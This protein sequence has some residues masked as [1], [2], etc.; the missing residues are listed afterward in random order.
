MRGISPSID[1]DGS[2]P[3]ADDRGSATEPARQHDS[4]PDDGG[5][6]TVSLPCVHCGEPT[7]CVVGANAEEVFCCNGCRGAYELIQGLGL[8]DFY[9][10]RDQSLGVNAGSSGAARWFGGQDDLFE[11]FDSEAFLGVSKPQ[12][13][14]GGL[15]VSDLSVGGLHC[16]ACA[17]LIENASLQTDGW[18][19]ARVR[20]N[21]HTIRISFDPTVTSLSRIAAIMNRL[22]YPVFP[23]SADRNDSFKQEN[24]RLLIRIAIAGFCAAN[25]MWIAIALYAGEATYVANDHRLLLECFGVGLGVISVLGPGRVFLRGALSSIKTRTPHMD[26]PVALGLAVGTVSGVAAIIAGSGAVYF[27]SLAVLVFLLLVGRWIQFRQQHHAA[28][29]VD[30]LLRMTPRHA[31]LIDGAGR[32]SRVLVDQLAAGQIVRVKAGESIPVDGLIREGETTVDLAL[33]TGESEPKWMSPGDEVSAGT[34]NLSSSIDIEVVRVGG[35][36]RI[37]KVMSSVEDAIS[38]K[39]PI[40]ILADRIGGVFVMIVTVLAI[41]TFIGWFSTGITQAAANATALLIVAC[42]CALALATPLAVAVAIGRSAKRGILIRD[43]SALERLSKPGQIWFDKTGTLTQGR[44]EAMWVTGDRSVL[45][46]AADVEKSCVHPL[47]QAIIELAKRYGWTESEQTVSTKLVDGG[48]I[49]EFPEMRVAIG[50]QSLMRRIDTSIDD[51]FVVAAKDCTVNGFSPVY[52]AVGDKVV[53]LLKAS[54]PVRVDASK[55]IQRL[56]RLGWHVGILSGDHPDIVTSV[57]RELSVDESLAS[58]GMLPEDKLS[59]VNQSDSASD[60]AGPIIMVGDGA[61]DAAALTAAD[62]GIAVRGGAE[63]SLQAAPIFISTGRLDSILEL[64]LASRRTSIL[65]KTAFAV[66]LS[67]NLIAVALAMLGKISPLLAAVFMPLSSVSVLSL[68]LLW[69]VFKSEK[70]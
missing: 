28:G 52:I 15:L 57:A 47:A 27:D 8:E 24:R 54:D 39:V 48:V 69:P 23:M 30:L 10:L 66:S 63:V 46:I 14:A 60:R 2:N 64:L 20:M 9:A 43:G 62:V 5:S 16:A 33:L 58:G 19:A 34:V 32:A 18:Q 21:D 68:T 13:V 56:H 42:P 50:N 11:N 51:H 70:S 65:I 3:V 6:A 45:A 25:A 49:G 67:Y 38:E 12:P 31:E 59:V 53:A 55:T 4:N 26:L 1:S 37:G 41:A 36:S 22:G 61:N 29:S 44:V 35:E 40:V 7:P 17:W